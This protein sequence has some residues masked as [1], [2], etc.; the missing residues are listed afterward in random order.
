MRN[1]LLIP[2][3]GLFLLSACN[4]AR[5]PNAANFTTAINQH[6]AKHGQA[7]TTVGRQFPVDVPRSE[8]GDPSGLG[9]KLATLQQSG[10][11]SET[12]TIAVVYGMLAPLRG[13][14]PP[15]PVR[16]YQLTAEGQKYFRQIPVAIGEVAGF[17]YGQKSVDS[18]VNWT[19]PDTASSQ[20][21]ITYTYKIVN[22]AS[23]AA[24]SDVQ[25]A[26]PDIRDTIKGVSMTNQIVGVQLTS[27]GWEVPAY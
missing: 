19:Q 11:V 14:T 8:H 5:E 17:C 7:C 25:Q 18:I 27:K 13:P 3:A 2:I 26:F 15:Q 21:E 24:R 10:L 16:R 9:A 20:A 6:L 23:W 12:D 1:L 4:T 22:L